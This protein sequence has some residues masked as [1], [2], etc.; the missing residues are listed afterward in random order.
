MP[1]AADQ[2]EQIAM[3]ASRGIA[4]F[5]SGTGTTVGTG[6]AHIK[7]APRRVVDIAGDPV[8]AALAS[9]REIMT[10]HRLGL[11]REA[12]R[13]IAGLA[14]HSA[15]PDQAASARERT[16]SSGFR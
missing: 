13:Q 2:I 9:V 7:A 3:L 14:D 6:E 12:A 8:T 16:A 4:P 5:A 1:A 11:A 15:C 10:A